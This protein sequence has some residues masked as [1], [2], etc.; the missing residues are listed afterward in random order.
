MK[1]LKKRWD[2][3]KYKDLF[4]SQWNTVAYNDYFY[5]HLGQYIDEELLNEM[6]AKQD[7]LRINW[8]KL[9]ECIYLTENFIREHKEDLKY[10][11]D[12][13]ISNNNLSKDFLRQMAE[14]ISWAQLMCCNKLSDDFI[15]EMSEYIFYN[16]CDEYNFFKNREKEREYFTPPTNNVIWC[17]ERGIKL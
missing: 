8:T 10:Y 12:A 14:E 2:M 9:T 7:F 13:V 4:N 11:W 6:T 3:K 17:I 5:K 1:N 16:N 15:H